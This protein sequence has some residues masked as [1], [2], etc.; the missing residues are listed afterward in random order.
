[1]NPQEL[2]ATIQAAE[3]LIAAG[4]AT[5]RQIVA[6]VKA[7]RGAQM[8]DLELNALLDVIQDDAK[9]RKAIA[10]ADV[11]QAQADIDA[12]SE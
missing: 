9:R 5:A 8:T 11:A 12:K 6:W 3:V 4:V 1:M 2:L 10:D 7:L